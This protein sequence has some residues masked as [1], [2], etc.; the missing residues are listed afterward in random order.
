MRRDTSCVFMPA[1]RHQYQGGNKMNDR[2]EIPRELLEKILANTHTDSPR[3]TFMSQGMGS[4]LGLWQ[5]SCG[6]M[7]SGNFCEQCGAPIAIRLKIQT[8]SS[9]KIHRSEL[10]RLDFVNLNSW[11]AIKVGYVL[12]VLH[13]TQAISAPNAARA[14]LGN[15]RCARRSISVKNAAGAACPN[16]LP[17]DKSTK[18]LPRLC[19]SGELSFIL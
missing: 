5:C 17:N 9:H 18:K 8:K 6:F 19:E 1:V 13:I 7:A 3:P 4:V 11:I 12:N 16:H 15:A 10:L 14:N 2:K